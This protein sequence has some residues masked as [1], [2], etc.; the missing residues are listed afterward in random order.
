MTA[1]IQPDIPLP[2]VGKLG[3]QWGR[4]TVKSIDGIN[5]TAQ[6]SCGVTRKVRVT[7]WTKQQWMSVY[8]RKC[9]IAVQNENM[10]FLF[11]N[12]ARL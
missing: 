1:Q 4:W 8:C 5:L 11:P 10:K 6:C 12:R 9:A 7:F 2:L 3:E